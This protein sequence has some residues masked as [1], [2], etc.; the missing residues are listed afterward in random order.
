MSVN[1]GG[2]GAKTYIMITGPNFIGKKTSGYF[3]EGGR[4]R[5]TKESRRI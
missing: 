5:L 3:L 4:E 2:Q 1:Q